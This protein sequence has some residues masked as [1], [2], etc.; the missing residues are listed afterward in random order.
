MKTNTKLIV[1]FQDGF[2]FEATL[3]KAI[4]Y[5]GNRRKAF[6]IAWDDAKYSNQ[7][8]QYIDSR[9]RFTNEGMR[10]AKKIETILNQWK[11]EHNTYWESKR[12]ASYIIKS[13]VEVA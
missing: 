13:V 3:E 9:T 4:A 5:T 2:S 12:D 7:K 8:N 6:Y 10:P 11:R 1:T